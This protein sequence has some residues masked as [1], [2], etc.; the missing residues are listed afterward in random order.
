MRIFLVI[1]IALFTGSCN[2]SSSSPNLQ[3]LDTIFDSVFKPNEPG[4][5]VLIAKNGKIIYEK[6]FGIEDITTKK[7]ISTNTL[8]NVG[9]ISKTFVAYGILQLAKE[10]KLSL[11]DELYKYFPYFKDGTIPKKVKLKHMLTHSSGLPNLR[12]IDE[13]SAFYLT[14]KDEGNWEP[15]Y[16]ADSLDF[17][18]GAMYNYSNISFNGL[19]LIIEKVSGMKWQAYIMK[20]I[21]EPSG[22]KTSVIQDG[23]YP[24]SGVSHAY[25][26]DGKNFFEKDYGEEPTFAASGNGGVWSSVHELWKYEQ[27]IQ[28]NSFLD[29]EWINKSRTIYS[30]SNWKDSV[31][32][33]LGL[34]W[35]ITK[36]NSEN[37]IGHTGS[38]GGFRADYVWLPEKKIFYVILCNTPKPLAALRTKVLEKVMKEE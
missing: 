26:Y 35:F 17:E 25:W 33:F 15:V 4:G 1:I 21:M 23:P 22:M 28:K 27:A 8:F 38:Q 31:P 19:A 5:A 34:S 32:A 37:M 2:T 3:T 29:N 20:N 24:E 7:P 10:N 11:D 16:Q 18:P 6:G 14:A 12:R 36:T 13:D 9:S 30:H